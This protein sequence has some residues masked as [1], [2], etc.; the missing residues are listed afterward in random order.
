MAS[1]DFILLPDQTYRHVAYD[2][3]NH[4]YNKCEY[5]DSDSDDE[6]DMSAEEYLKEMEMILRK[7]RI[8]RSKIKGRYVFQI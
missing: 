6:D 2:T 5:T 1:D 8:K 7:I 3:S 4:D